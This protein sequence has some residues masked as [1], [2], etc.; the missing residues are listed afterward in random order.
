MTLRHLSP[1]VLLS[2]LPLCWGQSVITTYLGNPSC[3]NSANDRPATSTWL[4]GASGI[5][6]GNTNLYVNESGSFKVRRVDSAGVIRAFA[7]DSTPG[8][9]GDGGPATSAQIFPSN[10]GLAVDSIGNVYIADGNNQRVRKVTPA[11]IISTVAGNGS[12]GYSGDGGPATS[13]QLNF[14][15]YLTVD[16]TDNLYISDS[17]N[18]RIRKVDSAGIITTFAGNGNVS[19]SGDGGPAI[20]AS[21]NSPGGIAF[22]AAGNLYI[23]EPGEGRVRKVNTAGIIS[24]FAGQAPR[25][26][27]F[28]GDGGPATSAQLQGPFGLAVD[29]SGAIYIADNGNSRIRKVDAAGIITTYAGNGQSVATSPLGDGGPATNAA[30]G[31]LSSL[32]L[33]PAG[34]LYILASIGGVQRV[35][36]VTASTPGITVAPSSLSFSYTIGDANPAAQAVAVANPTAS[37]FT[38]TA[39][40][41]GGWLSVSPQ[42]GTTPTNISVSVNAA[43]LPGGSYQGSIAVSP[44]GG[45]PITLA[46]T[47]TVNGAGAPAFS[48]DNVLN[49]LGYQA[50]LA[51]GAMF[52]IFGSGLGPATLSAAAGPAYP[53]NLAG[54]AVT[55][56]PA[57]G[58]A[59][60]SARM[61]YTSA[62]QIAGLLPS[63]IVP[64]AYAVRITNNSLTSAPQTVTIVARSFG[65]ATANSAGTG[66]AQATIGNVNNG[67]SLVRLTTGAVSFNGLDWTL[68]PAHPGDTL[69]FWGTGGG[70]DPANDTGGTSGDQTAAG[71]FTVTV[72]GRQIRPLYAGASSGYPGLWQINF[73]LPADISTGCFNTAQVTAGGEASNTVLIPIAAPGQSACVDT[74]LN[75]SAL[76]RL[77]AGGTITLGG[78]VAARFTNTVLPSSN[79]TAETV[80][81]GIGRYTLAQ[82]AA[83]NGV[84]RIDA[85][86]V[87]DTTGPNSGVGGPGGYLDAGTTIP[88]SGPGFA[89]NA[90][91][92]I[93]S[94][95][96]G[97]VYG[98][99]PTNGT[100]VEGAEYKLNG[101][102]GADMAPFTAATTIPANFTIN[103]WNTFNSVDRS[104]PLAISWTGAPPTVTITVSSSRIIGRNSAN[105]NILHTVNITCQVPGASG[106]YSVPA[107][108]L[109]SLDPIS[110]PAAGSSTL[111]V[112]ANVITPFTAALTAGGQVDY[113]AFIGTI[114]FS[115][116]APIQ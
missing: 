64:G 104:R 52:V 93:Q 3:C 53:T 106:S 95:N 116:N 112:Q 92:A 9:G 5:A 45:A 15:T 16:S 23:S 110:G 38:A 60:L 100:L 101:R 76:A 70:A 77:D 46:V 66:I 114:A 102:G 48:S 24:I 47:L 94:A 12:A 61:V 19:F 85:C 42:S 8:F 18:S 27:G 103:N 35:R 55:F 115:R 97:P 72:A 74:S 80:A 81:G 108:A 39:S 62:G 40:S 11:G 78:I 10:G 79:F 20:N 7:G 91:L 75:E 50:K 2:G 86:T 99:A 36:R 113:A 105:A 37:S 22:D 44:M 107:A 54:T 21:V 109:A 56:T 17:S 49:A 83:M 69:V 51:P 31:A 111:A 88:I 26:R 6:F 41:T 4:I 65:I 58:G 14:P 87:V 73:T 1:I 33:D 90:A 59:P 43:G 30:L 57:A 96:P 98:L 68:S 25:N 29:A 34:N 82:F 71:N 84:P 32:S 28:S 67:I 89:A 63:S 13:A